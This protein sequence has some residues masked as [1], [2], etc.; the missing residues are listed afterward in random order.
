MFQQIS[1]DQC[2]RLD[3]KNYTNPFTVF[4]GW[5]LIQEVLL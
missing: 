1:F 2:L 5:K 4:A 3:K